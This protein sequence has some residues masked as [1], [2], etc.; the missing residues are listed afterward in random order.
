[1]SVAKRIEGCHELRFRGVYEDELPA[2]I[3]DANV[4]VQAPP[5]QVVIELTMVVDDTETVA[6]VD[7]LPDHPFEKFA[8]ASARSA[9]AMKMGLFP[10]LR[11]QIEGRTVGILA[12]VNRAHETFTLSDGGN[13]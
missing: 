2:I 1:M 6:C 13:R 11:R 10:Q 3:K 12:D 9:D 8:L 5:K 4:V 7:V